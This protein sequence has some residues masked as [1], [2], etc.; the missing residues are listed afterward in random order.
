MAAE[1]GGDKECASCCRLLVAAI[2]ACN[3]SPDAQTMLVAEVGAALPE[4]AGGAG[5]V[6]GDETSWFC[7]WL[8][9]VHTGCFSGVG[10]LEEAVIDSLHCIDLWICSAIADAH[11][12]LGADDLSS[13]GAPKPKSSSSSPLIFPLSPCTFFVMDARQFVMEWNSL[14]RL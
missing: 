13:P 8:F 10:R 2:A 6:F 12:P 9:N 11:F 4:T 7:G 1:P 5:V 3:H 14:A